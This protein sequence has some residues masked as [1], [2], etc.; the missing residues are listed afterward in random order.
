MA[1]VRKYFMKNIIKVRQYSQSAGEKFRKKNKI[2]TQF[3]EI[4]LF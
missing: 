3:L 2:T 4:V 1:N